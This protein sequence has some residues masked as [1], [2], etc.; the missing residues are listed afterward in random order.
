MAPTPGLSH[1]HAGIEIA[2]PAG[3]HRLYGATRNGQRAAVTPTFVAVPTSDRRRRRQTLGL[4]IVLFT[5]GLCLAGLEVGIRLVGH[6]DSDGNFY[7]GYNRLRPYHMPVRR[8][9]ELGAQ[10]TNATARVIYDAQLGWR[11][12]PDGIHRSRAG[13]AL[14]PKAPVEPSPKPAEGVLRIALFGDSFTES[15]V[16]FEDSWGHRL[17]EEL[18][19]R[20]V[21]NEVFNF[22]CAGYGIDQAWLRWQVDGSNSHPHVVILGFQP[23]NL[24]RNLNLVRLIYQYSSGLPFSKPRFVPQP[25]GSLKL[26]NSPPVP[27]TDVPQ[28]L[29]NPGAWEFIGQEYFYDPAEYEPRF[30]NC[31]KLACYA[32]LVVSD[33][34]R[35]RHQVAESYRP[36]GEAGRLGKEIIRRFADEARRAN[37]RFIVLNLPPPAVV[38]D[39]AHGR[40]LPYDDFWKDLESA[41]PVIRPD[42]ALVHLYRKIGIE[43]LMLDGHFSAAGDR[44][45]GEV[46]AEQLAKPE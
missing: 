13:M 31:S 32:E 25:D 22:G 40:P 11:Q 7:V 20:G 29:R 41:Y 5:T 2:S 34:P 35:A 42:E 8:A 15:I 17:H 28:I 3:P 16:S 1:G 30:W 24:A 27:P 39:L 6:H 19:A 18:T 23:E 37:A 21:R 4:L 44:V 43:G 45:L 36:D 46:V 9:M 10:T 14:D 38:A 33:I 12:R 26:A